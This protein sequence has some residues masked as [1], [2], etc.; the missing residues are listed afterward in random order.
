MGIMVILI[1][2]I[3]PMSSKRCLESQSE[4]LQVTD[5]QAFRLLCLMCHGKI[6]YSYRQH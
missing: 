3:S 2:A 6:R 5:A 1:M 4:I